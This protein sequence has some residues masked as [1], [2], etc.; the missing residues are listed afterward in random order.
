MTLCAR[1]RESIELFLSDLGHRLGSGLRIS[2]REG[3]QE[4]PE[5]SK[6]YLTKVW[7]APT[8]FDPDRAYSIRIK[9]RPFGWHLDSWEAR[10]EGVLIVWTA[11]NWPLRVE[12]FISYRPVQPQPSENLPA[13]TRL[14]ESEEP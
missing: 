5:I 14:L 10:P 11:Q 2:R 8:L 12:V 3:W 7:L 13:L 6:N 4:L 9:D 1:H